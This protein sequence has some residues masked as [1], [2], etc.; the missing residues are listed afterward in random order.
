MIFISC[1]ACFNLGYCIWIKSKFHLFSESFF[2]GV[3]LLSENIE[4]RKMISYSLQGHSCPC[5]ISFELKFFIVYHLNWYDKQFDLI[6]IAFIFFDKVEIVLCTV[7]F[8]LSLEM[9]TRCWKWVL[10]SDNLQ[11]HPAAGTTNAVPSAALWK[12]ISWKRGHS[13]FI[14][15]WNTKNFSF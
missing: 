12:A 2:N 8:S 4:K 1:V 11:Q 3:S 10:F 15:S 7:N 9:K 14:L 5:S 6:A 13:R